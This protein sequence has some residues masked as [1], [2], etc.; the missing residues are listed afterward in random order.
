MALTV[1]YGIGCGVSGKTKN[2]ASPQ[3]IENTG[4]LTCERCLQ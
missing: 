3:S 2:A 1:L 4:S